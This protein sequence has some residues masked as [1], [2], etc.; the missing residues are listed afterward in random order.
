L[1]KKRSTLK[2]LLV[3]GK[4]VSGVGPI[5]SDEI[6]FASQLHPSRKANTL[7][8]EEANRLYDTIV[9]LQK[10]ATIDGGS[11]DIPMHS[12]DVFSGSYIQKHNVY[13][14]EQENCMSCKTDIE[15]VVVAKQ[16]CYICSQCQV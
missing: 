4:L 3:E 11:I 2:N 14:R 10:E 12:Q 16:K 15:H 5:Y 7:L 13:N 1:S 9:Q 6:L 8:E